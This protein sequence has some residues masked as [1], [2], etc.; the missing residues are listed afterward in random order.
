[1]RREAEA[2]VP[3]ELCELVCLAGPEGYVR[4]RVEAFREA[5][6]TMLDVT[7]VGRDPARL[8]E[9]VRNWL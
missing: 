1:M 7:P 4:E 6:V 2:A 8:V 9:L 5:G 3:A